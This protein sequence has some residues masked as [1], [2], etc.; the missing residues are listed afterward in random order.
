MQETDQIE[1]E[2]K[3]R[4]LQLEHKHLKYKNRQDAQDS[5]PGGYGRIS[6]PGERQTNQ[7]YRGYQ[8]D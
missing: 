6:A 4:T 2:T 8:R 7:A 5:K 3:L 1:Y